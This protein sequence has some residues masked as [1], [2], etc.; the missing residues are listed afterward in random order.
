MNAV[1]KEADIYLQIKAPNAESSVVLPIESSPK[2]PTRDYPE[3]FH[4]RPHEIHM[5]DLY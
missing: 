3:Q 5:H 2:I 4:K 1:S